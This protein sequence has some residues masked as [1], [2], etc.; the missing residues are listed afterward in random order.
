M[1]QIKIID[2]GFVSN[3][4]TASQTQLSDSNRAGYTGSTVQSFTLEVD[5]INF[6]IDANTE[7][8]EIVNTTDNSPTSLSSVKN[9]VLNISFSKSKELDTSYNNNDI[10]ELTRL[11]KT[12][13]LKLI[14]PSNTSEIDKYKTIVQALGVSN[15]GS[16]FS[17]GTESASAGHVGSAT[18]YLVGRFKTINITDTSTSTRWRFTSQFELTGED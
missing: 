4:G 12:R 11:A 13:G 14:Y 1:A 7:S 10:I 2:T 17:G 18:P 8:K 5:N 16:Y 9:N 15:I 3:S 6:G